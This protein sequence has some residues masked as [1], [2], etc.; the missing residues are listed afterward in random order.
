LE[1]AVP[2]VSN[3]LKLGVEWVPWVESVWVIE[4]RPRVEFLSKSPNKECE[5]C[6]Q[7]PHSNGLQGEIDTEVVVSGRNE[8]GVG[9]TNG[10]EG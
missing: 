3:I 8:A 7:R 1:Y 5:V 2:A 6:G 10:V 9:K 4:G